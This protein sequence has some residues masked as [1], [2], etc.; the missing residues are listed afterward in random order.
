MNIQ[1]DRI[2]NGY[3]GCFLKSGYK[4]VIQALHSPSMRTPRQ[5]HFD[6]FPADQFKP[7]IM[8]KD[9]GIGHPVKLIDCEELFADRSSGHGFIL[10]S[11]SMTVTIGIAHSDGQCAR[12]PSRG[13]E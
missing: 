2:L 8:G 5:R 6:D 13:A 10:P 9:A 1:E 7:A 3:Y 12:R 4:E 11:D